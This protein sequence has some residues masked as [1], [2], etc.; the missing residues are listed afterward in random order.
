[1]LYRLTSD[2]WKSRVQIDRQDSSE[3][4]RYNVLTYDDANGCGPERSTLYKL[5]SGQ[6]RNTGEIS[7]V[8]YSKM[9]AKDWLHATEGQGEK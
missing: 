7:W 3:S 9:R 8:V 6:P 5:V 1:M 2:C 4:L